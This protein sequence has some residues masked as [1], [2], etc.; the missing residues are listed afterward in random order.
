MYTFITMHYSFP[1]ISASKTTNKIAST[2]IPIVEFN[3]NGKN[4][5][6]TLIHC[7]LNKLVRLIMI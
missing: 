5:T 7:C 3:N 1:C 4:F 2:S 6:F